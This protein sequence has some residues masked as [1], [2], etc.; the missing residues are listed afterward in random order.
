MCLSKVYIKEKVDESIVVGEA[1]RIIDN[2][3]AVEVYTLFG[4]QKI[5]KGYSIKE[6]DLMKNSVVLDTE[7]E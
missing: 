1:A 3:V 4:E 5:L 6:V 7:E 2:G